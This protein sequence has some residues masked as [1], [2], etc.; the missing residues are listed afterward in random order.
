L[1]ILEHTIRSA[2]EI[3]FAPFG[4]SDREQA[5]KL[6]RDYLLSGDVP[7]LII[8][9]GKLDERSKDSI[10]VKMG[11]RGPAKIEIDGAS[12]VLLD[13][14]GV[15]RILTSDRES[16]IIQGGIQR[17]L[18]SDKE[19]QIIDHLE[20]V[21]GYVDLRLQQTQFQLKNVFTKDNIPLEISVT[22]QY[23]IQQNS[24]MLLRRNK[25]TP[26]E[27]AV[28]RAILAASDWR[29][30]V[31]STARGKIRDMLA[32][33]Y[34]NDLH[35]SRPQ[36]VELGTKSTVKLPT[37]EA[38]I[39][40]PRVPLQDELGKVLNNAIGSWGAEM[41]KVIIDEIAI[42]AEAEKTLRDAWA[43]RW[44]NI[45]KIEK[46]QI[47]AIV[48]KKEA[49]GRKD[50][51]EIHREATLIDAQADAE[52][53]RVRKMADY[54]ASLEIA[55][56][57]EAVGHPLDDQSLRELFRSSSFSEKVEDGPVKKGT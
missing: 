29:A 33:Y 42:P 8:T 15:Q 27:D 21:R 34:L 56:R 46:A 23:R 54:E 37:H 17:V 39:P 2:S 47:D 4:A 7:T 24:E 53:R 1:L 48:A 31:E 51:A 19:T 52:A 49:E 20:R 32:E 44:D 57:N 25:Y 30:Q 45:V 38:G 36:V 22:L 14:G 26:S 5:F 41:V 3:L 43:A 9:D 50:A 11:M 28:K 12:A 40:S 13:R 18:M 6:L 35:G 55:R 16:Q 10:V